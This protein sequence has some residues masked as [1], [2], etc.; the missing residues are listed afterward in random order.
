MEKVYRGVFEVGVEEDGMVSQQLMMMT[1][2]LAARIVDFCAV[3]GVTCVAWLKATWRRRV[4]ALDLRS[5]RTSHLQ[6]E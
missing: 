4:L 6:P 5:G 2:E 3:K 1:K